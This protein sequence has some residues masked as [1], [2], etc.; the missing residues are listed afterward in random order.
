MEGY[1]LTETSPVIAVNYPS[2]YRIGTVGK[3]LSNVQ[4][5]FA[6]DGELEV[7]GPSVFIGYWK[8]EKE[9]KESFT[10]DGWFK[11]G[12]IGNYRHGRISF[13]YGPEEGVAQDQWG[14]S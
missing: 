6:A 10:D 13:D 1:G 7:K 9:T 2:A 8:K 14:G 12:D 4:C 5:R 11:T 3:P